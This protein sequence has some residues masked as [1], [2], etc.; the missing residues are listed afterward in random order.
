MYITSIRSFS[1]NAIIQ[2]STQKINCDVVERSDGKPN[3]VGLKS[4]QEEISSK[5][6]SFRVFQELREWMR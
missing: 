4:L 2:S 5:I 3:C 6:A 1:L